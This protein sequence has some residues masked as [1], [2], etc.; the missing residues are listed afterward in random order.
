MYTLGL[1]SLVL[2]NKRY[3]LGAVKELEEKDTPNVLKSQHPTIRL[4]VNLQKK[5]V[6]EDPDV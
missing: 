5:K 3:R 1:M 2:P 4:L 6:L